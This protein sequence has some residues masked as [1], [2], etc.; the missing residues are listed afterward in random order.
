MSRT[1][2]KELREALKD[3]DDNIPVFVYTL[4]HGPFECNAYLDDGSCQDEWILKDMKRAKAD[5]DTETLKALEEE[6]EAMQHD[7]PFFVIG[8][9]G[10]VNDFPAAAL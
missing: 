3:V 4:G 10:D 6:M 8:P 5:G 2:V 7:T 1:T 9:D